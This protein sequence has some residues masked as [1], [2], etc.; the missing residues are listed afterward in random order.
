[1]FRRIDEMAGAGAVVAVDPDDADDLGLFEEDALD[2]ADAL[3]SRFDEET[4]DD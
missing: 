4:K 3:A 2:T 1:M